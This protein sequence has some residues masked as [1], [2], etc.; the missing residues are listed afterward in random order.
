MQLASSACEKKV[1]F[2]FSR[3]ILRPTP[4]LAKKV[5]GSNIVSVVSF[6]SSASVAYITFYAG[7]RVNV[8]TYFAGCPKYGSQKKGQAPI[9]ICGYLPCY[10]SWPLLLRFC[11]SYMAAPVTHFV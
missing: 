11:L 3:T 9:L 1:S 4:A 2:A 5:A 6:M 10:F 7:F 8:N